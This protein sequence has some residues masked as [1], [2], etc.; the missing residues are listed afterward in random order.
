Q[1]LIAQRQAQLDRKAITGRGERLW[2][3]ITGVTLGYGYQPWRALLFLLGIL[4]TSVVLALTLGAHGALIHPPHPK[5]PTAPTIPCTLTEQIDVGLE[6]GTPL[7][8]THS[9][10][11]CTATNTTT[12]IGLSYSISALQLLTGAFA[13]LF[14]AG[15]TSI[16]RKT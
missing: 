2:V 10:D 9:Q 15:F 6:V 11:R 12:G 3:R 1:I 13:A 14:I 5:N 7:L 16:V 8:N 4:L